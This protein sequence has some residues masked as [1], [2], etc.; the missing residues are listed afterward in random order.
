M[1][2][3]EW[4]ERNR[5]ESAEKVFIDAGANPL[6]AKILAS[7]GVVSAEG[8]GDGLR[9][10]HPSMLEDCESAG[11]F[12]A[13]MVIANKKFAIVADYDAD[14][15]TGCAV[16]LR[17]LRAA[18]VTADFV[19]PSR[20][21]DG[22]GMSEGVAK[23]TFEK[24]SPDVVIT[25]DNGTSS[26]A[27]VAFL[28]SKGV[29]VVVTDH[30]LP[31]KGGLPPA[32]FVVNPNAR[33]S[34][35]ELSSL[36]GVGVAWLTCVAASGWL[37]KKG[38]EAPDTEVLLPLVSLGTVADV[39]PLDEWNRDMVTKGLSLIREGMSQPG[40]VA[41]GGRAK[42]SCEALTTS[43]LGFMIAPR[44]NA[45]GRM[46]DMSDG[47][48]CL[49]TDSLDEAEKLSGLLD[50]MN[51][52]R[53]SKESEMTGS[54]LQAL[55]EVSPL[56]RCVVASGKDFHEGVV[57]IV[58]SRLKER[59]GLPAVVFSFAEDGTAKGSG[60]SIRG[61]HMRDALDEVARRDGS[62]MT[63]F[64]GHAMAAGLTLH[65]GKYEDFVRIFAEVCTEMV[66]EDMLTE[67]VLHDGDVPVEWMTPEMVWEMEALPFGQG[68]QS[69]L[70]VSR[71]DVISSSILKEAH[72]KM[73]LEKDGK[74]FQGIMFGNVDV[75]ENGSLLSY[76][77]SIDGWSGDVKLVVRS[78]LED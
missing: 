41:L 12:V 8:F 77:M 46:G 32:D 64:G 4:K 61:F 53:R 71:F 37:E 68:F 66:K 43:D 19:V 50:A 42:V 23:A 31:S 72:L 26:H 28:K 18:G 78:V 5:N 73:V 58:A 76:G 10:P 1:S 69:P 47:I 65:A 39:V 36:A 67:T 24:M 9:M 25:V 57:G 40:I 14:G 62:V 27:G 30:H 21:S 29:A 11:E 45:A 13:D 15:A 74:R 63:K 2:V 56:E 33:G 34:G 20:F 75:P 3:K 52:E 54:A 6:T 38:R 22:Y 16:M 44:L 48:R 55:G 17:W 35:H 49:A 70:F 60:R 7:R 51:R 59:F